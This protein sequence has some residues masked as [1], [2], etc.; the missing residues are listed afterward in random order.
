MNQATNN[1]ENLLELINL[2]TYYPI[3]GGVFKHTIGHV[4]AVDNISF[5]IKMVK[6]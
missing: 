4:K 1:K 3:K 2:K 5:S 6:H